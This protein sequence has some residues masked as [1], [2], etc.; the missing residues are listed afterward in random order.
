MTCNRDCVLYL[1]ANA[2]YLKL[3]KQFRLGV[4]LVVFVKRNM[5]LRVPIL[6]KRDKVKFAFVSQSIDD[7]GGA[8]MNVN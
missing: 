5:I 2:G 6:C 8:C 4:A 7:L 3:G 1:R